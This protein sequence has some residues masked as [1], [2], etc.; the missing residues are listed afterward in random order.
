MVGFDL[1]ETNFALARVLYESMGAELGFKQY[2][3]EV[4][5]DQARWFVAEGVNIKPERMTLES[6]FAR[7]LAELST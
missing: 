1:G 3:E 2:I 6:D 5:D 7:L 4:L